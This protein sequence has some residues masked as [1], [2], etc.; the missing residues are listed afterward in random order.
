MGDS[1]LQRYI[2]AYGDTS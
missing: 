2:T 1:G